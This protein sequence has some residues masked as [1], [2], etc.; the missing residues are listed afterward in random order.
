MP[1]YGGAR[2]QLQERRERLAVFPTAVTCIAC[3]PTS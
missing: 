1:E 3:A 2:L